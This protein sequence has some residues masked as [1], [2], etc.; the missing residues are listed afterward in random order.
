LKTLTEEELQQMNAAIA[1]LERLAEKA[2]EF[3]VRLMVD[4][5]QT[6]FQP[7][8]DHLVLHLQR[9]YNREFPVIYNTYQ[10]Y[11]K[12][13][14]SRIELDLARARKERFFFAAKLVRGAYMVQERKRARDRKYESPIQD[15]LEDTHANYHKCVDLIL[16]NIEY[17]DVMVAS[18]NEKT[19]KHVIHKMQEL[20]IAVRGGGVFFGQLLGMC[21]HV[22]FSLGH[23]GY[24]VYKYVPYG[25]VHE[26]IPYLLRRAEE[27]SN[28]LGNAGKEIKLLK[29]EL[30]RR[31]LPFLISEK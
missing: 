9:K 15:T 23:S 1:R 22:S 28:M 13:S 17:A 19:V 25:P 26:V 14:Y 31:R 3:K 20:G 5:E 24:M 18:H 10:S 2:A 30:L 4:A 29:K 6:Y 21:D 8:I 16:E 27:N 7:A 12:D 11:L